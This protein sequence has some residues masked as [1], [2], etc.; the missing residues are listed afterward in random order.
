MIAELRKP[1]FTPHS[2]K[3]PGSFARRECGPQSDMRAPFDLIVDLRSLN[4]SAVRGLKVRIT[5]KLVIM[6][7]D[8]SIVFVRSPLLATD[9]S[10]NRSS[11]GPN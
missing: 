9:E 8:Q 1:Q 10:N 3:S 7:R 5:D 6:V 2:T 11:T 4:P